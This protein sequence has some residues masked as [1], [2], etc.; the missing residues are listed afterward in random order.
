MTI[1]AFPETK[2]LPASRRFDIAALA[3]E[4]EGERYALHSRYMNEMMVRVFQTIGT[5]VGFQRGE[6]QYLYDGRGARYL[7][8]LSGWGVFAVGRNHPLIREALESVLA[9]ELP[10][11]VQM[12]VS[13]LAGLLAERLLGFVPYLEKVFFA[14][15]G[16]E[17]VEAALK[18]ARRA[19]GRTEIIH[20]GHAFHGLSYGAL[21]LNGDAIFK[22]GFGPLLP[23]CVEV[24]FNDLAA[25]EKALASGDAAA[26]IV[27]PIQGKGVNMPDDWYLR[28]AAALCRKYGALFIADEIQTGLGRT[29]RFL[30]VEHWGVEPD[31]VLIAKGLSGGHVPVG[32]VLTRKHVFEKVFNRMDRAVIHGS[33]FAKNDIAMA[34]G[35]ATLEVIESERLIANAERLGARLLKSF[36]AMEQRYELVKAVRGKGLMI[37][38]EF[39]KPQSL[40][41]K[42]AWG[43]VEAV[44]P[45]L[46][47]QLITLPLFE[48]HKVLVQVAGHA[49]HTVKLLPT[50]VIDSADCDWIERSFDAVIADSHRVPGAVWTL[51]KTLADHA[52]KARATK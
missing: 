13:V 51:G 22:D 38:L 9:A 11:L 33:T 47:C 8:L 7:D 45:G 1:K 44:N 26:F 32:A 24:P 28:D 29:G 37:G 12:D 10:N 16:T 6:G 41:L 48:Q 4:R 30:A 2:S 46:F 40:K 18:F 49:S 21:S 23:G 19:T 25:L 5:D 15:S 52:L 17:A 3:A 36:A 39:G 31:M 27:E 34:A 14:N 50:L 35:L 43:V 20:C 42:A